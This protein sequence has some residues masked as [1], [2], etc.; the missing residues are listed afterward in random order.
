MRNKILSAMVAAGMMMYGAS[1]FALDSPGTL[2][3]T[4]TGGTGTINFTGT[5]QNGACDIQTPDLTVNFGQVSV[6]SVK[7]DSTSH[8]QNFSI[9]LSDCQL[10]GITNT[11]IS[12]VSVVFSDTH[13]SGTDKKIIATTGDTHVGIKI[14][15]DTSGQFLDVMNAVDATPTDNEIPM[16]GANPLLNFT[17]YLTQAGDTP[18]TPGPFSATATYTLTYS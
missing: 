1:A 14:K 11:T 17:A 10:T 4:V 3:A 5:V 16:T 12:K 13:H 2:P 15:S 7:K 9:Q 6:R 18:V 8:P